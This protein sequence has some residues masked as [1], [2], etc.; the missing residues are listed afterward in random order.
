MVG[1]ASG[2]VCVWCRESDGITRLSK[3]N[4]LIDQRNSAVFV[5]Y[6]DNRFKQ[7]NVCLGTQP[8]LVDCLSQSNRKP[9]IHSGSIDARLQPCLEWIT[10][11]MCRTSQS[12]KS[13]QITA[14]IIFM[15]KQQHL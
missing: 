6:A 9:L 7:A 1:V 11:L 12:K 4:A 13:H 14:K 10:S 2:P 15:K 5:H 3:V 8:P